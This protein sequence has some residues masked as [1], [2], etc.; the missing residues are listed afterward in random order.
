M[1]RYLYVF[2]FLFAASGMKAQEHPEMKALR[3]TEQHHAQQSAQFRSNPLTQDY[4]VIYHRLSLEVDPAISY[5]KGSVTTRFRPQ[6]LGMD[7]LHFDMYDGLL[8]DSITWHN[9]L[10]T[11]TLSDNTLAINLPEFLTGGILDSVT[12]WYQG[13]PS[14]TG[15]GSFNQSTH[16][17]TPVL[18]TLSEPYGARDWWPCKQDLTDKA[19]SIDVIIT[20]PGVYRAA[21]NGLLVEEFA[22]GDQKV[23]HWQHRYPIAAY[24]VAFAVTDY[25]VYSDFVPTSNEP[26]EVLNYVYPEN[27]A[28]SQTATQAIVPIMQL[29]NDLFGLYP[30]A[31]EKYGHAQFGWG[32]GM[33]HQT[34]SF[35]VGFSHL[36]MAH[37]LAHQWFGDKV[38]C[39]S[40]ED[41]WLNEGF[42]TYLEGLNYE[43]GIGPTDWMNW[44][45]GKIDHV[46]SAPGGSVWVN[47]TTSVGRIFNS[48]LSYSKGAMVLH[49]LRWE[50]GDDAFFQGVRNYLNDPLNAYAYG[51]TEELITH[52]EATSG[53]DL[54]LF[55]QNWF[56][57]EGFPTYSLNW[58]AID[59]QVILQVDQITSHPS[60]SFFPMTLPIYLTGTGGQDTLLRIPHAYSGETFVLNV[61]WPVAEIQLDPQLWIVK[62]PTQITVSVEDPSWASRFICFPNPIG[63]GPLNLLSPDH[64]IQRLTMVDQ[65]GRTQIFDYPEGRTSLQLPALALQS[66]LTYLIITTSKGTLFRKI[67]K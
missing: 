5:I 41:I 2:F 25:A 35:M 8:I 48:R 51:Q 28:A 3:I 30:F 16:N 19:D 38:T 36:L 17:N 45:K 61:P 57:G 9:A 13:E 26:V 60:V 7:V 37:E 43:H 27:L 10:C 49:M 65:L 59:G 15:F 55:F 1:C 29:Y 40:W 12:I 21:S 53:L 52:L 58:S 4:D 32:G 56:Y 64:P 34:M 11:Y 6:S 33:E 66:G 54:T 18:W 47:D 63:G 46:I 50:M 39:A 14:A 31:D 44:K 20:T 67:M 42:A 22:S 23:Y 24:L 62:G